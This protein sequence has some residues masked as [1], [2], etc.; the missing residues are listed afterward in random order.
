M[1]EEEYHFLDSMEVQPI[2]LEDRDKRYGHGAEAWPGCKPVE[3]ETPS[4]HSQLSHDSWFTGKQLTDSYGVQPVAFSRSNSIQSPMYRSYSSDQQRNPH[5]KSVQH[6]SNQ[7]PLRERRFQSRKSSENEN[8]TAQAFKSQYNEIVRILQE[9]EFTVQFANKLC[10]FKIIPPS[11]REQL[12]LLQDES[13]IQT[14]AIVREVRVIIERAV[15]P[16]QQMRRVID[17]LCDP[18][19]H[20]QFKYVIEQISKE[21]ESVM[22]QFHLM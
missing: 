18:V 16:K 5:T 20:D 12:S 1:P 11:V 10:A 14:K 17:V 19:F 3:H 9:K 15:G 2:E 7:R 13:L 21:G 22:F 6:P 4:Y 8:I